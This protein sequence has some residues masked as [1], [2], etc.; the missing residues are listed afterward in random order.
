MTR[1]ASWSK[2]TDTLVDLGAVVGIVRYPARDFIRSNNSPGDE[3]RV[4]P[5][6]VAMWISNAAVHILDD[7][8]DLATCG[9]NRHVDPPCPIAV[10]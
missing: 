7:Q 2:C 10:E 6:A 8:R 3:S 5:V 1:R 4:Q 9:G